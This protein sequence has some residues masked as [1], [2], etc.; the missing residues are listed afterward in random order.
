MNNYTDLKT[1]EDACKYLKLDSEKAIPNF[2]F[3][4]KKDREAMVAHAKLIIISNNDIC[5]CL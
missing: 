2:S 3:Y 5:R 4:P 1:F